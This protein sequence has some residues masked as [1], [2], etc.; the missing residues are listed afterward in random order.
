MAWNPSVQYVLKSMIVSN[1]W[2]LYK[3]FSNCYTVTSW[4]LSW[5]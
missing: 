4:W 5:L 1:F 2:Q 3:C